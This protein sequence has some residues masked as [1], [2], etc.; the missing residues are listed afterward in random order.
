[1]LYDSLFRHIKTFKDPMP[2]KL[3]LPRL[4][5][6]VHQAEQ[7]IDFPVLIRLQSPLQEPIPEE[8]AIS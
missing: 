6:G 7:P 3:D 5:T 2:Q 1:M 4:P 8:T